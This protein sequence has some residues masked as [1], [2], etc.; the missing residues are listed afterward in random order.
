[1]SKKI[2]KILKQIFEKPTRSD[3]PFQDIETL[4]ISLGFERLEG[5]GS[6]ITFKTQIRRITFHRPHP[7]KETKI[8]V[9][10]F[11][12]HFLID[13]GIEPEESNHEKVKN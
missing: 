6:R 8:Y 12:R 7:Q 3:I 9:I 1:M 10:D 11:L 5:R 13:I 4:L 2:Q